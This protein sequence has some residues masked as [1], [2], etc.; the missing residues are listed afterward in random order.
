M[1]Y[2]DTPIYLQQVPVCGRATNKETPL[3]AHIPM[4]I[5]HGALDGA[6]DPMHSQDMLKALSKEGAHPG[7]NILKWDISRIAAYSDPMMMAWLF[8]QQSKLNKQ[9]KTTYF[10]LCN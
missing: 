2:H 5:F 7:F 3:I 1:Q 10:V 4:W 6:V 9:H 8:R